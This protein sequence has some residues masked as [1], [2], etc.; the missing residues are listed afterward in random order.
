[1]PGPARGTSPLAAVGGLRA[2]LVN[3][4]ASAADAGR[5]ARMLGGTERRAQ[6]VALTG[7]RWGGTTRAGGVLVVLDGAPGRYLLTRS[8]GEDG[9]E[10]TT[11]APTDDRRLRHRLGELLAGAVPRDAAAAD[12]LPA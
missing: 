12:A 8:T 6:L 9:V 10:W 2:A 3:N 4:G 7:D 1:P 11:V 5:L